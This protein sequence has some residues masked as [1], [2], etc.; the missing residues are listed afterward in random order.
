MSPAQVCKT[1]EKSANQGHTQN[2]E[3]KHVKENP[4]KPVT[5]ASADDKVN[6]KKWTRPLM[7]AGWT[8]VP[9]VLIERQKALGLDSVD[10]NILLHLFSYWW[11]PDEKPHP[12][13]A[14]IAEA[15]GVSPRTVQRRIAAMERLGFIKR[16]ERRVSR[17][18]SKTN[19]YHF[20]GLIKEATPLAN[21][22][23]RAKNEKMEAKKKLV[24]RKE[25]PN[26]SSSVMM[27]DR[28]EPT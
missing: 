5:A 20:E 7:E 3:G 10:M 25:N 1:P 2:A 28:Q 6:E 18:G 11:R 27:T 19:I 15:V 12:A 16:Q 9:N 23:V 21:E 8:V 4:V 13:K 24:A 17:V 26:W 14:T 22:M